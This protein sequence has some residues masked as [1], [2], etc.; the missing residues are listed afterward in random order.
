MHFNR[1]CSVLVMLNGL[2]GTFLT[3]HTAVKASYSHEATL[4]VLDTIN[5]QST[6]RYSLTMKG[7]C[8]YSLLGK[9]RI[10]RQSCQMTYK[11]SI[12]FKGSSFF[13]SFLHSPSCGPDL[14]GQCSQLCGV[15]RPIL[16]WS[17]AQN[18]SALYQVLCQALGPQ[19]RDQCCV[20]LKLSFSVPVKK[21]KVDVLYQ[22]ETSTFGV[23]IIHLPGWW[24]QEFVS[25]N[26]AKSIGIIILSPARLRSF[27][28]L[29]SGAIHECRDKN[30]IW[31]F[32][33]LF[34]RPY[35]SPPLR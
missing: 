14:F 32:T 4:I 7:R 34:I 35:S 25:K 16:W 19:H 10:S 29:D 2:V 26:A 9:K 31:T 15:E 12:M 11:L 27:S 1:R 20:F 30:L 21:Q 13:I 33:L 8:I 18:W 22:G 6:N 24:F 28:L 17:S 5:S 3:Y 23:I